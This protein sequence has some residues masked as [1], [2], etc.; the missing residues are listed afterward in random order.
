[1]DQTPSAEA[2][3]IKDLCSIVS[4]KTKHNIKPENVHSDE[5]GW[6]GFIPSCSLFPALPL[7]MCDEAGELHIIIPACSYESL[8]QRKYSVETF[9]EESYWHYGY[10]HGGCD[11]LEAIFWQPLEGEDAIG[12][13]DTNRI[14]QFF[15]VVSQKD[16]SKEM[17]KN[18]CQRDDR[19]VLAELVRG[20]VYSVFGFAVSEILMYESDEFSNQVIM[21]PASRKDTVD[22]YLP[23]DILIRLM[24]YP[25]LIDCQHFVDHIDFVLERIFTGEQ[26]I[27]PKDCPK[28]DEFC[29]MFWRDLRWYNNK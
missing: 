28:V 10:Y 5:L 23:S 14:Q 16:V 18:L 21:K 12:M 25:G 24:Y 4:E 17:L 3:W 7:L 11:V 19:K 2:K 8:K 15:N 26:I 27:V 13:T 29:R 1:M 9:F 20:H 22:I 6:K